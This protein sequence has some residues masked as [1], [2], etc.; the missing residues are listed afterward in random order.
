MPLDFTVA[1]QRAAEV[2]NAPQLAIACSIHS[3]RRSRPRSELQSNTS[4]DPRGHRGRGVHVQGRGQGEQP[5]ARGA[6]GE[7]NS[8]SHRRDG[9]LSLL[10]QS[11]A[12]LTKIAA[13]VDR[14]SGGRLEFGIGAGWKENEYRAYGYEFPPASV[15]V[16]QLAETLAIRARMWTDERQVLAQVEIPA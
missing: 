2:T 15:R 7:H 11:G 9:E 5:T 8:S 14:I 3:T 16:D 6:R 4:R 12:L 1:S 13:S 10:S